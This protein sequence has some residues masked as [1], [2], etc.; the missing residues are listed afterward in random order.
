M[1]RP[2]HKHRRWR[3]PHRSF[4]IL[5]SAIVFLC[6]FSPSFQVSGV[7]TSDGRSSQMAPT[8]TFPELIQAAS[9]GATLG[10]S[11]LSQS[12]RFQRDLNPDAKIFISPND[13]RLL[14]IVHDAGSI[15]GSTPLCHRACRQ[16]FLRLDIPPP[17]ESFLP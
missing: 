1:F 5:L 13:G 14:S 9:Q 3:L 11:S 10:V 15:N 6:S 4:T 7:P 8:S 12:I 16:A 2:L 17:F